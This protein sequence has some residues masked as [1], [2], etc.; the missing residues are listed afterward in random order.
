MDVSCPQCDTLY[1]IDE[2][3]LRGGG[4]T[5]KCSQCDHVFRMQTSIALNQENRRRWMLRDI[6]NGDILYFGAFDQ[7]HKWIMSGDASK[8]DEISRTGDR[9]T[10]LEDIGEFMPIFKAVDSISSLNN[11]PAV[12]RASETEA[13][14][15]DAGS[16][17]SNSGALSPPS[18]A[19]PGGPGDS[20]PHPRPETGPRERVKTSQQFPLEGSDGSR[21]AH[22]GERPRSPEPT[23]EPS[24]AG[25]G[26]TGNQ[27]SRSEQNPA[28]EPEARGRQPSP[29][30]QPNAGEPSAP[31]GTG[32]TNPSPSSGESSDSMR[33]PLSDRGLKSKQAAP[34][35][36]FQTGPV[37]D[38]GASDDDWSFGDGSD[39]TDE[40]RHTT[41]SFS[42]DTVD[43][44]DGGWTWILLIVAILLVGA[45]G[46]VYLLKPDL[47]RGFFE[48][49]T[50]PVDIER[51]EKSVAETEAEDAPPEVEPQ[52]VVEDALNASFVAV[53]EREAELLAETIKPASGGVATSVVEAKSSADKAAEEPD[54]DEMLR[55]AKRL[56]ERGKAN[57]ARKKYHDV[58]E[59]ERNNVEAVTGL[60]WSLLAVGS[61]AAAAA[62]F[63]RAKT[64]NPSFGDAYIGLGKAER[65]LGNKQ[66]ALEAYGGY[67]SR[68]PTGRKSSIAKY[69]IERLE[70]ELGK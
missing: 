28:P 53:E 26:S 16:N 21:P 19:S 2:Q 68:F 47:V 24:E 38:P 39:L 54:P 22:K 44:S 31:E 5:L 14:P 8:D 66:A 52:Q 10:R 65:E 60:G 13:V 7:L 23:A 12:Q 36:T 29:R 37:D 42:V 59:I 34:E 57:R 41:G 64:V 55:R 46:A 61:P 63:R 49:S 62:Q 56:L 30:A 1:E 58:L 67:L 43:S 25:P 40:T 20:A 70:E 45:G 35:D 50:E 27:P 3:Q 15:Q 18:G 48:T 17:P 11:A 33:S 6:D 69:Q 32:P 4:A 9:W 51:E